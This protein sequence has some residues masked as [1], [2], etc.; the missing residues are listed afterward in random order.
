M[1][2]RAVAKAPGVEAKEGSIARGLPHLPG[3]RCAD[4]QNE[5]RERLQQLK[6]MLKI[7]ARSISLCVRRTIIEPKYCLIYISS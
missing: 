1:V 7:T 3:A 2:D 4:C 6:T 5:F